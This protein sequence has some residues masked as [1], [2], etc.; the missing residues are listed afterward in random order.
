MKG[1][2]KYSH[3]DREKVI[4]E[5]VPLVK[6]KFGDNLIALATD[7]SYA[8][9]ED[10]DYSD[11]EMFA[12]VK[13]M[14]PG[15]DMEGMSRIR[16]GLLVEI[17]WTTEETYLKKVKEVTNEWYLAGSDTLL[18]IINE[19]FIDEL[20]KYQVKNLREK[21][22]KELVRYWSE[23][24]EAVA[25][26]LNAINQENH[27]GLPLLLFYMMNNMLVSLSLLNQTPY[28]TLGRFFNQARTFKTK[29]EKFDELL[30][31]II[32]GNYN[33]LSLLKELTVSIFEGFETVIEK[34]GLEVYHTSIDPADEGDTFSIP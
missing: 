21:C 24:Q 18:P 22:Q 1:L 30:D 19:E 16:D 7:G 3:K 29:P 25:K 32:A 6:K 28:I 13:D 5:L 27:E 11:L 12:F 31:V 20:N 23:V 8:R 2:R 33:D 14:P 17:I 4:R 26:V 10:T 9:G 15:K 34:L